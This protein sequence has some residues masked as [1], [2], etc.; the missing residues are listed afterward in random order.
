MLATCGYDEVIN[1]WKEVRKQTWDVAF[2]VDAKASV[3]S[4]CW[5]PWEY[6][7]ILGAGAADGKIWIISRK[8][9]DSW[10]KMQIES[11]S[12]VNS[13]SWGPSTDPSMLSQEHSSA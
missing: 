13:I 1:I 9:D 10:D 4:I 2:K 6:G 5:A 7:L 3:G 8:P 11:G 12:G